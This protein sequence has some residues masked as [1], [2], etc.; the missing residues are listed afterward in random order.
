MTCI[1]DDGRDRWE[2][3]FQTARQ[4]SAGSSV[5]DIGSLDPI[6]DRQAERIDQNV[7]LSALHPLEGVKT[8][9]SADLGSLHRLPVH[10]HDGWTFCPAR[11]DACEPVEFALQPNPDAGA[12]P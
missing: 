11:A 3:R 2:N 6:G 4:Q 12:L 1:G 8:T 9:G 5:R 10:D 7:T